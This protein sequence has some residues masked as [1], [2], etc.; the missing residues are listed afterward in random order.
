MLDELH[1][2]SLGVIEDATLRLSDGLTVVT[3]ET[4]AG[5]TMLVTALQLLMGARADASL[6]RDGAPAAVVEARLVPAPATAV[7]AGWATQPDELVVSREI[8][9]EG[10]SRARVDGRLA[11]AGVLAELLG[12]VIEVHA[13]HDHVRLARGDTQRRLL[14]RYAGAAHARSL[15]AYTNVF[16]AWHAAQGALAELGADERERVRATERLR[17][18]L[19]EIEAAAIDLD[20]DARLDAEIEVLAHAEELRLALAQ[21]VAALSDE[22]AAEPLGVAVET[23]RR[24]Q[25]SEDHLDRLRERLTT[26]AEGVR[27][28]V[29]DLRDHGETV[30]ADPQRLDELQA[31]RALLTQLQRKY[32]ADLAEVLAYAE[33]ARAELGALEQTTAS[34]DDLRHR[35]DELEPEVDRLADDLTRGRRAAADHL[36]AAVGGHLGDLGMPHARFEVEVEPDAGQPGLHG[37]DRVAYL[38]APNPGDPYRPVARAA[39]GG[40]R[41]RVA[42]AVEA[43]LAD[44]DDADVLVFDEVDAGVGGQTALAVGAKLA[45]LAHAGAADG[46]GRQVLCVTHLAQLAAFADVHHVVEKG[47]RGGRA[48]TTTRRVAAEDREAELSRMLGGD[49]TRGAGRQH[50]RELLA[51]ARLQRAG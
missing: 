33:S 19:A 3:G 39:S 36:A 22:G 51:E 37:R 10:R 49:A 17:Y 11:P 7:A 46:G 32:G 13:Q 28:L 8:P 5:K 2:R 24:V 1:I 48:V 30:A 50:A 9:A 35:V 34:A 29:A 42:L 44:V 16:A 45:R 20:G 6:V 21:A 15:A 47:V 31:R 14:D 12:E 18:E 26:L 40:E 38:L 27:D 41:S 4:G 25:V 43:A 23:L